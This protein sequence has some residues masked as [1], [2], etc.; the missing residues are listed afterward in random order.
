MDV[1]DAFREYQPYGIGLS[2]QFGKSQGD[3]IALLVGLLEVIRERLDS[4][5]LRRIGCRNNILIGGIEK[6]NWHLNRPE[7]LM[8]A[9]DVICGWLKELEESEG[10]YGEVKSRRA[11]C[12]L[13]HAHHLP[14]LVRGSLRK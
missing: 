10:E 2:V 11:T 9:F 4:D 12:L 6:P 3:Q 1:S 5:L 8:Q 13:Y 14:F 7:R